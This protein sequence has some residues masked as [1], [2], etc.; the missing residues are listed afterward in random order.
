MRMRRG[1]RRLLQ[2]ARP[3]SMGRFG[4]FSF[5][6]NKIITTSGGGMLVSDDE[7]EA[8]AHARRLAAQARD[9]APHYQH[10]EIGYNYRMSNVLAGI[11]RAQLECLDDRV[12]A[13]RANYDC[14]HEGLGDL[15]GS[16]S[17]LR[18]AG[19]YTPAG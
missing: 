12:R 15:P 11:G 1:P 8:I 4:V 18:P 10:S 6:G 19:A 7:E 3:G 2:R 13:R 9:P 14:S 16:T 5:N 17:C